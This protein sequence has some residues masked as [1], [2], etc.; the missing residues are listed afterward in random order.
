MAKASP[1]SRKS[2]TKPVTWHKTVG[3]FHKAL[4]MRSRGW[5]G[6]NLGGVPMLML[7]CMGRKSG[8][9]RVVPLSYA[10]V[11]GDYIVIASNAGQEKPPAWWYNLRAA[12]HA[13]VQVG[14]RRHRVSVTQLEGAERTRVFNR[15]KMRLPFY[16]HYD[17]STQR[18]IPVMR[19]R[20]ER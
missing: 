11:D 13:V 4:Y 18:E 14:P 17:R 20:P 10:K 2:E 19:L 1:V 15:V 9:Q 5:I 8:I 12:T 16:I 6:W 7:F 3:R